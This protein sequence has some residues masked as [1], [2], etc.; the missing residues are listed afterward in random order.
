MI[1]LNDGD[2][3]MRDKVEEHLRVVKSTFDE[4]ERE[5]LTFINLAIETIKRGNKIAFLGNEW[6]C[7]G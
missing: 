4:C 3:L 7:C 1:K 2:K 5:I 6:K